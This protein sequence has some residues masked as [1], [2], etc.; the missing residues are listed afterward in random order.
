MNERAEDDWIRQ[1][2]REEFERIVPQLRSAPVFLT[3]RQ[4]A[5][6]F[7]VGMDRVRVMI[8][9][10]E[11]ACTKRAWGK[12]GRFITLINAVDAESKLGPNK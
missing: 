8:A 12:S 6:R 9:S 5:T 7:R 2:I 4:C 1:I 3:M 10:G 11:L